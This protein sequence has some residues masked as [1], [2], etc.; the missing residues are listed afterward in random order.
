[1]KKMEQTSK[2]ILFFDGVCHLCNGLVDFTLPKFQPG[3]IYFAPLQGPTAEKML[4]PQ[5]LSLDYVVYLRDGT[6]YR[7]S[8]AVAYL[9]QDIG[10]F[11]KLPSIMLHA[12]PSVISDFFYELVAKFRYR[13]FG[14]DEM[15][16]IPTP[17]EKK[18]FLD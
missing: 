1:M 7:R 12:L 9:L 13:L 16:R 8:K 17:E 2:R 3:E 6:I 4:P 10:G 14:K 15:C 18:Y 5:D 11:Y